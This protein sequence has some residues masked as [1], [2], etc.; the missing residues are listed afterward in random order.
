MPCP[1]GINC[2]NVV[3]GPTSN[4]GPG[5]YV[6]LN[7]YDFAPGDTGT[8]IYYCADPG[9]L[10]T[11]KSPPTCGNTDTDS[12]AEAPQ[13]IRIYPASTST[14]IP[15]GTSTASIQAAEVSSP[16]DP[17]SGEQNHPT[18]DEPG[19]YCDGTTANACSIVITDASIT[20]GLPASTSSNS[21]EIP[22]SFA[23]SSTSCTNPSVVSTESEFGIDL[24]M[25]ELAKLSCADDPSSAVVPFE[26][27]T[28]GLHAVTDLVQGLQQVAFTDDPEAP[29]QQAELAKGNFAL[30]PV[31]LTANVV[32]FYAQLNFSG[33]FTLDQMD[34]TPT[35]A[36]GLL[37]DADNYFGAATTDNK[38]A[39][40]GPSLGAGGDCLNGPGP[41]Y[42]AATCSLYSQLNFI[43]GYNQFASFQSVERSDASGATGQLFN[44][45]C[46][47]PVVPLPFGTHP[48]ESA[49][50]A[51]EL[52]IGLSPASNI[53]P[54]VTV[55]PATAEQVP[56]IAGSQ[57]LINV[58]DPSQQALKANQAVF[59]SGTT[60][61]ATA[62]FTD[63]NWAES[64][65]YGMNV[66]ALQNA[67][68]AFV[69]PSAASLD[70]ALNDAKANPDGTIT[71]QNLASDPAA[72]PMPS[73]IYA[74]VPT[75]PI[76]ADDASSI[77]EMLTQ[78]LSLTSSGGSALSDLPDGFAPLPAT[79]ATTATA[80]IAKD[81]HATS[82]TTTPPPNT[83]TPSTPGLDTFPT[84]LPPLNTL[85][86]GNA[87]DSLDGINYVTTAG[88]NSAANALVSD[89]AAG[90]NSR[91]RRMDRPLLGPALPGYALAASHGKAILPEA[92]SIGL[93]GIL[94]GVLLMGG[95][96]AKRRK[97]KLALAA[98]TEAAAGTPEESP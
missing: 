87:F 83:T 28:D 51:T 8:T 7:F 47:A 34:L 86:Y 84:S 65:Y 30:I 49:S 20:P 27:A 3:A 69:A 15:Q 14:L 91:Q 2:G 21:V 10:S 41:C 64:R 75:A 50:G 13:Q 61:N 16:S 4:L 54:P 81:I 82:V 58:N 33:N 93:L 66:A 32:S 71:P 6:Y 59:Q 26:T 76:G 53:G 36:A 85:S 56:S 88:F 97:V 55:C 77:K 19:F 25:P 94:L 90:S 18:V 78:L 74:V 17:I 11:L 98:T 63:M 24:L 60:A 38:A 79:V 92:L 39:C 96:L 62:A 23:S 68:G 22:V 5:Q 46:N 80:D 9:D 45:L 44:W 29:D 52:D 1:T 89:A 43:N 35:M 48:V 95:G 73:V 40:S 42:G 37:T 70:A 57:R 12:D 72:Y 31:A 67:A